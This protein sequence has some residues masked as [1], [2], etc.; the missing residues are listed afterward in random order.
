MEFLSA[1]ALH[2]LAAKHPYSFALFFIVVFF[3]RPLSMEIVC[4]VT[5]ACRPTWPPVG[6]FFGCKSRS[7]GSGGVRSD[8]WGAKVTCGVQL[9]NWYRTYVCSLVVPC[10]IV[11]LS[12]L[13]WLKCVRARW[14]SKWLHVSSRSFFNILNGSS[15]QWPIPCKCNH[16]SL[17]FSLFCGLL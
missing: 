2:T 9:A 13:F 16:E 15:I 14:R 11:C 5:S 8:S 6:V 3:S 7:M 17:E 12:M 10:P 1:S 4:L